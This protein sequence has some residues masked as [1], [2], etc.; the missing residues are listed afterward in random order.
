MKCAL[1]DSDRLDHVKSYSARSSIF[2]GA[3]IQRCADCKMEMV[4]PLPSRMSWHE[5]NRSYFENAHGGVNQSQWVIDYNI[6][7]A[8]TRVLALQKYIEDQGVDINSVLEI[9]PG[10]GY[11]MREFRKL[12]PASDY[13]VV[14]SDVSQHPVLSSNGATIVE[15]YELES[16]MF[17]ILIA[18][19]VLEHSL[20]PVGFLNQFLKALKPNGVVFIETPCRDHEYKSFHEP[21]VLFF[22]KTTLRRCL[23]MC[24]LKNIK[25]TYNGDKIRRVRL[26]G[27]IR[28]CIIKIEQITGMPTHLFLGKY[29]PKEQEIQLSK[30]QALAIVE[31]APHIEQKNQA[32]WVRGFGTLKND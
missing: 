3:T 16:R 12:W 9:G 1:C 6:G 20:D 32:R 13:S 7:L 2:L 24:G 14:E 25:M 26:N 5:Y 8:R 4:S 10:P 21:H 22:E 17:D 28:K 31:T 27:F 18:T 19:H 29:W 30:Q 15:E 23:E 11:F